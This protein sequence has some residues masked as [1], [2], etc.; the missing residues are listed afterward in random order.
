VKSEGG[1]DDRALRL[2]S[3]LESSAGARMAIRAR[4]GRLLAESTLVD[5]LT[6]VS[7]LVN[8]GIEHGPGRPIDVRVALRGDVIRGEVKD[9]GDPARS[10]PRLR[11]AVTGRGGGRGL[12]LVDAMTSDWWV[13]EGSTTVVFEMPIAAS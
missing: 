13:Q 1:A 9:E 2:D 4:F 10:I 7:E 6:V 11:K 12:R 8:N 3:R 5:L